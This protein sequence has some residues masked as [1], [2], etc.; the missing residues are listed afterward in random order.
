MAG[1]E[2]IRPGKYNHIAVNYMA[3]FMDGPGRFFQEFRRIK[4]RARG[5][6]GLVLWPLKAAGLSR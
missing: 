1:M 3:T 4:V 6:L 5:K 2:S